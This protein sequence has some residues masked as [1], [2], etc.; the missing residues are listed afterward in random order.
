MKSVIFHLSQLSLKRYKPMKF[1]K[2]YAR[3]DG[4]GEPG[5]QRIARSLTSLTTLTG[6]AL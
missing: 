6:R 1:R 4:G 5:I 2:M 3:E